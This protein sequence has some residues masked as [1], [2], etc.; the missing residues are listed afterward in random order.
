[1]KNKMLFTFFFFFGDDMQTNIGEHFFCFSSL[2]FRDKFLI[3]FTF[4]VIDGSLYLFAILFVLYP[5]S[6][7]AISVEAF[8]DLSERC[9]ELLQSSLVCWLN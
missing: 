1:M 8:P 4:L 2:R 7:L 5:F 3:D 9:A 6:P